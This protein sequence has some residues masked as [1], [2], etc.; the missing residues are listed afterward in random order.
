MS[1]QKLYVIQSETWRL[2][3]DVDF[4]DRGIVSVKPSSKVQLMNVQ[5]EQIVQILKTSAINRSEDGWFL[6]ETAFNRLAEPWEADA[7]SSVIWNPPTKYISD[8]G[9]N[10]SKAWIELR[11]SMVAQGW[12]KQTFEAEV[13]LHIVCEAF[14][15][16]LVNKQKRVDLGFCELVP[17]PRRRDF[18][19]MVTKY[20]DRRGILRASKM[21]LNPKAEIDTVLHLLCDS[22]T[23]SATKK[24][25]TMVWNVEVVLKR[26]WLRC[27]A[28]RER[29]IRK[30]GTERYGRHMLNILKATLPDAVEI[31]DAYRAQAKTQACAIPR[32]RVVD[33]PKPR[34]K[35]GRRKSPG[36]TR[37]LVSEAFD[38]PKRRDDVP[39]PNLEG[40]AP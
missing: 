24:Y 20:A 12:F 14:L 36:K 2:P 17:S 35:P 5:I 23:T 29:L 27:I 26:Y 28:E 13:C 3:V 6:N 11:D 32:V 40:Q 8:V 18:P 22:L 1:N 7:E 33:I 9:K 21:A 31:V 19:A 10:R 30:R 15:D 16:R 38:V 39:N 37:V 4:F 34:K 25:A